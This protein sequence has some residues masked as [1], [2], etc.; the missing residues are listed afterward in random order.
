MDYSQSYPV[1]HNADF[2]QTFKTRSTDTNS[3]KFSRNEQLPPVPQSHHTN[4]ITN[5]NLINI[6]QIDI[7]HR[8]ITPD[9]PF[10]MNLPAMPQNPPLHPHQNHAMS[11]NQNDFI[12]INQQDSFSINPHHPTSFNH[13]QTAGSSLHHD[14]TNLN[15]IDINQP[16]VS[17][18]HKDHLNSTSQDQTLNT[19]PNQNNQHLSVPKPQRAPVSINITSLEARGLESQ[20]GR[21]P[22]SNVARTSQAS[23]QSTQPSLRTNHVPASQTKK[24]SSRAKKAQDESNDQSSNIRYSQ[25][26]Q[27]TRVENST[28]ATKSA[29]AAVEHFLTPAFR[30][31]ND[32]KLSNNLTADQLY[33][34]FDAVELRVMANRNSK[35]KGGFSQVKKQAVRAFH[36]STEKLLAILCIHLG[37]SQDVVATEI[38]KL[39]TRRALGRYDYF[40][41]SKEV[42]DIYQSNGGAANAVAEAK[43]KALYDSLS[44]E[45]K[46]AFLPTEP[47]INTDINTSV[48]LDEDVDNSYDVNP[49]EIPDNRPTK[50]GAVTLLRA[51]NDEV[52]QKDSF[53]GS[54]RDL[55][56]SQSKCE[57]FVAEFI[58]KANNMSRV[59]PVQFSITA[60]STH[61]SKHCFQYMA[62]TPGLWDWAEYDLNSSATLEST[63]SKMQAYVTGKSVADLVPRKRSKSSSVEVD[64]LKSTLNEI[65]R[66]ATNN[67]QETW[68]WTNCEDRLKDQGFTLHYEP[69]DSL[70]RSW[71]TH[72][73]SGLTEVK[74]RRVNKDLHANPINLIPIP[75]F[76]DKY[77]VGAKKKRKRFSSEVEEDTR[78]GDN[79]EVNIPMVV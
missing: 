40:K 72:A 58:Q 49:Q 48:D 24:P 22:Q 29:K 16:N 13:N 51:A 9:H 38:G 31:P 59:H 46:N 74:A 60:V 14:T 2:Q 71:I 47:D 12:A 67:S 3:S 37:I 34:R 30:L 43:V 55:A 18:M 69:S 20:N 77:K 17:S 63:P 32:L 75:G 27:H 25:A 41:A 6:N 19:N 52:T 28:T 76:V 42:K 70:Y 1:N 44:D 57:Q 26:N 45:E 62:T 64:K 54:G 56:R 39:A 11:L 68:K 78:T 36:N 23:N 33:D 21:F 10:N 61:L 79:D 50:I 7:N 35:G 73:S 15:C 53:R 5:H 66:K 8:L 4:D 65:I